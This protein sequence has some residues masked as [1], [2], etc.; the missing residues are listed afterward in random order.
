[1]S[2]P[3]AVS[4]L[5]SA[6]GR[7]QDATDARD[8]AWSVARPDAG[9]GGT[10]AVAVCWFGVLVRCAGCGRQ[11]L[12]FQREADL[13]RHLPLDHFAV[14]NA[15]ARFHHFE[16]AHLP[17]VFDACSMAFSTASCRELADV[18]VTSIFL[19]TRSGMLLSPW[20]GPESYS[21]VPSPFATGLSRL[22]K[23]ASR[24]PM[25]PGYS[26]ISQVGEAAR[27]TYPGARTRWGA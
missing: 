10:L 11:R 1:M 21:A 16:P 22:R 12:L 14:V 15:A 19:Y 27:V 6:G 9:P 5:R 24:P 23:L 25:I 17:T 26:R 18:P 2:A 4:V 20:L 13:H 8:L 3:R 7:V